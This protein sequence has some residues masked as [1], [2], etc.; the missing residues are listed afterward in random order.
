MGANDRMKL[1]LPIK[2]ALLS[3]V[4]TL[5][6]V[7]AVAFFAYDE[8]DRLLTQEVV[9]GY[10][11]TME[12]EIRAFENKAKMVKDDVSF[13]SQSDFLKAWANNLSEHD[14]GGLDSANLA[15]IERLF[16]TVLSRRAMYYQV[17]LIGITEGGRE[18]VRVS[19][20]EQG[21]SLTENAQLQQKGKRDY[22]QKS[23]ELKAG[24]FLFSDV[25]FN[26][27]HG[28]MTQPLQPMLRIS[29]AI[30]NDAGELCGVLL[31]NADF[32]VFTASLQNPGNHNNNSN[33]FIAT[34]QGDYLVHP[35]Q[36]KAMAF[37]FQR[38][39]RLQLDYQLNDDRLNS[40]YMN[41]D[42]VIHQY[43]F[44]DRGE[45]LLL[46][47]I[48]LNDDGGSGNLKLGA[49]VE[50]A[51]LQQQSIALRSRVLGLILIISIAL[52]FI[53]FLVA[54]YLT[55]PIRSM[56]S[57][58]VRI[59]DGDENV[60][61]PIFT[62]DEIGT[63]GAA[64]QQMLGHLSE[65]RIKTENL[66][67]ALE[68]QVSLR[69]AQLARLAG[70]LEAQNAELEQA[71]LSA[72]HA[73]TAKSQFLATMSHEIRTPLNG[74]LGLTELLLTTELSAS[75]RG[76]L[77][78]VQSSGEALLAILNDILDFSKIEA[79]LMET[80]LDEFNPNLI[81]EHVAKLFSQRVNVGESRLELIA[82]SIPR[83]SHLLIGDAGRLQQVMMNLM[84]NAVKF[85]SQGDITVAADMVSE[86]DSSMR[87]RFQVRDTGSGISEAD[88]H[89]LFEEFTQADGTD[90]RKHGGTGLGLAIGKRLVNLMGGELAVESG[91][92][93]GSCFFF[94]LD[95][96]KASEIVDKP[97]DYHEQFAQ[98][99]VLVVDDHATNR[100][101]LDDVFTAWGMHCDV[102][103]YGN[104]ALQNLQAMAR[105]GRPYDVVLIDQDMDGMDGLSLARLIKK[106]IHLSG[107]KT[108][109]M[110]SLDM[111][112]DAKVRQTYG[113]DGFMRKPLYIHSL[114]ITMLAVMGVKERQI[115]QREVV[116][117]VQ[118]NERILL[119]EDNAV[120]QQVAL[121]MLKNQGFTHIDVANHGVE[122]LELFS[123]HAYDLILMDIQMPELDGI[124]TT[125][126]IRELEMLSDD[127]P[128]PIIA[129]TAHALPEDKQRT[130]EAGMNG[131][132]TK[133]LTGKALQMMLA[134]WL[135][136]ASHDAVSDKQ[137]TT[138]QN[139]LE[140][141]Q[142]Q[143]ESIVMK[144][145]E[146]PAINEE[147]LRQLHADM[148]FG[149]GIILDTYVEELPKQIESILAAIDAE[150]ADEL[151]R[152]GHRL[153]GSSR[154]VAADS[155]G[156]LCFQFEELGKAND[157]VAARAL[158]G[159]LKQLA[160]QVIQALS[161][162]W[163]E[164][165][166]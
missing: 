28:K 106:D 122:A 19:R 101:M 39:E 125:T 22:F 67:V 31:I 164:E 47:N 6:G 137:L 62:H 15:A 135:P 144:N 57:A 33:F 56:I 75:Q 127:E 18:V 131:H 8:A 121:G 38:Q 105:A 150:N 155:L 66:N 104:S 53:T 1:S 124:A 98:W 14:N 96:K 123:Y 41:D 146:L 29:T 27:E 77:E 145:A 116:S 84:S 83:L 42:I 58:A 156:E 54:T 80:Q 68:Q 103:G 63:L 12:K 126:E 119:A 73:A 44:E 102:S 147:A 11:M 108:I 25:T 120:N 64:L 97:Q 128:V 136:L 95:L 51:Q 94:E 159:E 152:N 166:R 112:F 40:S 118:R 111:S 117:V 100:T 16:T 52:G 140:V 88:Q 114:F 49:V 72:E 160:E 45:A 35:S 60:T 163:L 21:V 7:I 165:I 78:T 9:N 23:I 86:C 149:I 143:V 55:R 91:V 133:P 92:G 141:S 110:T 5:F 89:K 162:N 30:F 85:T 130:H 34:S 161:A 129:L 76:S 158:T 74:V 79:G 2:F 154:S 82:R 113:L 32:N 3:F 151:R 10:T 50:I 148:G 20:S 134:E 4:I 107:I 115:V 87:I 24:E 17:R 13:L 69:T 90:T 61:I 46:G 36:E 26:R 157:L 37:E 43:L 142:E 132:L 59:G 81:I 153:K 139:A 70:R 48:H 71:V 93:K 109:M 65:T 99:R 138:E